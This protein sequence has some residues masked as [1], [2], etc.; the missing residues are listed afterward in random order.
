MKR[1]I[2]SLLDYTIKGTDGEIGKV[3]EILMIRP[4]PYDMVV[5][6]GGWLYRKKVLISPEAIQNWITNQNTICK[7]YAEKI[8]KS[9]Y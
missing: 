4:Q 3:A 9:R 6:T 2:N 7:S 1:S 8:K 5:K